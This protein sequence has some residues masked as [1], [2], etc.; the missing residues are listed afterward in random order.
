MSQRRISSTMKGRNQRRVT[1]NLF[2]ID[3]AAVAEASCS[4]RNL[5]VCTGSGVARQSCLKRENSIRR[6]RSMKRPLNVSFAAEQFMESIQVVENLKL[7]LTKDEKREL[8]EMPKD[9][10]NAAQDPHYSTLDSLNAAF[11]C[12]DM[13][14]AMASPSGR[15][16]GSNNNKRRRRRGFGRRHHQ[17]QTSA[18]FEKPQSERCSPMRSPLQML[19]RQLGMRNGDWEKRGLI[20]PL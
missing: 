8:W 3:V 5:S 14:L 19:T 6:R 13:P 16:G 4:I 20:V 9:P 17:Q 7:S 2:T 1:G 10:N 15:R 11:G 18:E 12:S